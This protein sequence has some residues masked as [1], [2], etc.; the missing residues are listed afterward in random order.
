MCI[1]VSRWEIT[2]RSVRVE[3][4]HLLEVVLGLVAT[5]VVHEDRPRKRVLVVP[6]RP[7]LVGGCG[8]GCEGW[9]VDMGP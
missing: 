2:R 6:G 1:S 3:L 9:V 5:E 8:R 4:G 7:S